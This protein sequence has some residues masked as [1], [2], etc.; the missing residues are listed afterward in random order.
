M[1]GFGV[2]EP[3]IS[4]HDYRTDQSG[5]HEATG[6]RRCTSAQFGCWGSQPRC[7][8]SGFEFK[9]LGFTQGSGSEVRGSA[10]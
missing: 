5:A 2:Q 6:S 1:L 3:L 9:G 4:A 10:V 7:Q 8:G